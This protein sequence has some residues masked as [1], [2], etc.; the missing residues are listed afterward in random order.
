MIYKIDDEAFNGEPVFKLA[1]DAAIGGADLVI[2]DEVSMVGDDLAR[3]L[4]SFGV[5][6]LVLGDPA[7]LP[8]VKGEGFFTNAEPDVML[9]EVHRQAADSPIIRLAT[10]I[11]QGGAFGVEHGEFCSVIPRSEVNADMTLGHDQILCGRN[12]T[13]H[14]MNRRV[15]D[16]RGIASET[17][18]IGEKL[19]CL[20]N[21]RIKKL[22]NGSLWAVSD[23][24]RKQTKKDRAA[25][26][27]RLTVLPEEADPQ[28]KG[29][30]VRVRNEFWDGTDG[31]LEWSDKKGTEE[32]TFGYALTCHK[33]QGS[34]WDSVIVFDEGACFRDDAWRW[35]YTAV[36][37]AAK[38]LT[39]VLA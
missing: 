26:V 9:T 2:I 25:N 39:M 7:Q 13:R 5:K 15:R 27:F 20:R 33:S 38:R 17:P 32:F 35:R 6:V 11:R 34:Q 10:T 24:P 3:D 16:L 30:A 23:L 29:I 37:R 22:L 36:T 12:K 8:P 18:T 31:D 1:S 28:A 19:V 14:A 21:D 4:L